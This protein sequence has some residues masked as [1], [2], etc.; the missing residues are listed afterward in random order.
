MTIILVAKEEEEEDDSPKID[1]SYFDKVYEDIQLDSHIKSVCIDTIA[2]KN[3][4]WKDRIDK[5]EG[6]Y[7]A[8]KGQQDHKALLSKWNAQ[9][10]SNQLLNKLVKP[11]DTVRAK[12][13]IRNNLKLLKNN[14][15]NFRVSNG[16]DGLAGTLGEDKIGIL[17]KDKRIQDEQ[18][19]SYREKTPLYTERKK[20]LDVELTSKLRQSQQLIEKVSKTRNEIQKNQKQRELEQKKREELRKI[21]Q[22][23]ISKK[24]EEEKEL[25]RQK[26]E[27]EFNE[28]RHK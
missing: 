4:R 22:E 20:L 18:V 1:T 14:P 5:E 6:F 12:N 25:L 16:F 28:K 27:E 8:P 19:K 13:E 11:N 10:T 7:P 17:T 9:I 3:S 26:R 21:K 15:D 23:E 2:K 24:R